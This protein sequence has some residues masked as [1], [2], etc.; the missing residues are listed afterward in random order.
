MM[1]PIS[2]LVLC[3]AV[4]SAYGATDVLSNSGTSVS[5]RLDAALK[6]IQAAES[7]GSNGQI[8]ACISPKDPAQ[9]ISQDLAA[10]PALSGNFKAALNEVLEV[11]DQFNAATKGISADAMYSEAHYY[12]DDICAAKPETIAAVK[13]ISPVYEARADRLRD[14]CNGIVD[15][16]VSFEKEY[17]RRHAPFTK[18]LPPQ[19]AANCR[20]TKRNMASI[21]ELLG[22]AADACTAASDA[23]HEEKN[24]SRTLD[25]RFD[26]GCAV[27]K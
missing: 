13:Q 22:K 3:L 6:L 26:E 24:H 4:P 12:S 7:D 8:G 10:L 1:K 14:V 17:A 9:N 27:A 18:Y 16:R 19:H 11:R 5:S 21:A 25:R 23:A 20:D 15:L 2:F